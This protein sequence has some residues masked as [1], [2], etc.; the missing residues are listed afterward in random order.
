MGSESSVS[1][2]WT[3]SAKPYRLFVPSLGRGPCGDEMAMQR[4]TCFSSARH[5][6]TDSV[7]TL[8]RALD[9]P[10]RVCSDPQRLREK[11]QEFCSTSRSDLGAPA[12]DCWPADP[13]LATIPS[14]V[15]FEARK[16]FM[17]FLTLHAPGRH[18]LPSSRDRERGQPFVL[19]AAAATK[20]SHS[21]ACSLSTNC[22]DT[23]CLEVFRQV[24]REVWGTDV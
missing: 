11:A 14:T 24:P 13:S 17:S 5:T 22:I 9:P 4:A 20:R 15:H 10:G 23:R 16:G 6:E 8:G 12:L 2:L 21:A 7:L 18:F 3:K 19:G 1:L